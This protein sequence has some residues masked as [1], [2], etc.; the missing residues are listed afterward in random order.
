MN[1]DMLSTK[2]VDGI[3]VVTL[4][5]PQKMY[6]DMAM[7]DALT[8]ELQAFAGDHNVRVVIITGGTPGY[9]NRHFDIPA[10]IDIAEQIRASGRQWPDNASYHGGFF[11][12]AMALCETMPK[13]VIAAIS[14]TALAGAFEFTLACDIRIAEDGDYLIG[15]PETNLGLLPGASGTQRLPRTVGMAAALW[16]ILMGKPLSPREAEARGFVHE[17]VKGKAIDR[18]MEIAKL[19]STH[20]PES[21]AYIKRLVRSANETPLADGL[22]LERNLFLRLC[23][24]DT[25]LAR[26]RNY[27]EK[28]ITEPS[29]GFEVDEE[30]VNRG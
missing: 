27:D 13:P 8:G 4:G 1:T 23:T 18:A 16:H 9:F 10:L 28:K 6:F 17:T 19:L 5:S 11:D 15:L 24:S 26:M 21:S 30:V 3:A 22:A 12:K 25:A 20:P 2:V 7:G 29:R 14:G